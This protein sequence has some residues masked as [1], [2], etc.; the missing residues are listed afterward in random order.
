MLF[1]TFSRTAVAQ[2]LSRARRVLVG[3]GDRVEILAQQ[4]ED[5]TYTAILIAKRM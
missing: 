2:I 5:G 1:L 3:I 4:H